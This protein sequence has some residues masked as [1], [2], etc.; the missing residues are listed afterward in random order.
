MYTDLASKNADASRTRVDDPPEGAGIV[1]EVISSGAST[2]KIS[3]AIAGY[4]HGTDSNV[5]VEV[6]NLS[7]AA[8]A[9]TVTIDALKLEV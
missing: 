4:I 7:G 2:F 1:A 6:T 8:A 3:P 9:I 5:T